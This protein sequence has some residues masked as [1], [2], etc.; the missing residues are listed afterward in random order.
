MLPQDRQLGLGKP[1]A[2]LVLDHTIDNLWGPIVLGGSAN[3]RGGRNALGSYRAPSASLYSYVSYLLG[4]FAPAAGVSATGF[5]G[6]DRDLGQE[7]SLPVFTVA[8]NLSLEWATDWI[9]LLV[10]VSVPYEYAVHSQMVRAHN[11]LGSWTLA[12]GAAF[13]PF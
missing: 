2:G 9:A 10:G 12:I 4:P 5:L 6:T 7:Q 8:G 1:T 11:R 3:W 13:A